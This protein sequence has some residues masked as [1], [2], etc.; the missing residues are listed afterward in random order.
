MSQSLYV[1]ARMCVR[2]FGCICA[3]AR[4][5]VRRCRGAVRVRA[6]RPGWF[7]LSL[8]SWYVSFVVAL[9]CATLARQGARCNIICTQPRRISAIGV[10]ERVADERCERVGQSVG[11]TIRLE[12][13]RSKDTRLLF[14]TTGVLLRRLQ[15]NSN[16]AGVSHIFVDE[17]HERDLNS[18]MLLILLRDLMALR[19]KQR[20][21]VSGRVCE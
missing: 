12:R 7:S 9:C 18:D 6:E 4:A 3:C 20:L 8:P 5:C 15:F 11:Y 17:V 13:K 1:H 21:A 2:V 14:C 10:S 19:D 16:L